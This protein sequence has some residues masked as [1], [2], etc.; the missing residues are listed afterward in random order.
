MCQSQWATL[1]HISEY[2]ENRNDG[3]TAFETT[4]HAG[5][6]KQQGRDKQMVRTAQSVAVAVLASEVVEHAVARSRKPER[7]GGG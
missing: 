1:M 7:W 4:L 3:G 5:R 6:S 2:G